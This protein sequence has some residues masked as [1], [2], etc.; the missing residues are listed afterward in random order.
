MELIAALVILATVAL[1]AR[2]H[3]PAPLDPVSAWESRAAPA[4]DALAEELAVAA[5]QPVLGPPA[6]SSLRHDALRVE[7]LGS[8]PGL[9]RAGTWRL[10]LGHVRAAVGEWRT[11]PSGARAALRLA[12]LELAGL[13]SGV[14]GASPSVDRPGARP[15]PTGAPQARQPQA[16]QPQAMGVAGPRAGT[17]G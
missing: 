9:A 1:L 7:R 17:A 10:A 16:S 4:I 14:L 8:P 12:G 3:P 15:R 6:V 2:P 11:D 5:S 13:S